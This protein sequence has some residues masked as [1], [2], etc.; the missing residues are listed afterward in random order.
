MPDR[1][2]QLILAYCVCLFAVP[3][4]IAIPPELPLTEI[5]TL[6]RLTKDQADEGRPMRI[7]GV[8]TSYDRD[9]HLA[10]LQDSTGSTYLNPRWEIFDP[11]N[12]HEP[13]SPGLLVE[14][15]G[16]S[17]GGRF[18]PHLAQISPN[19]RIAVRILGT[20]PLPPPMRPPRAQLLDP[21]FHSQWVELDAFVRDVR[22]VDRRLTLNLFSGGHKFTATIAGD[23]SSDSLPLIEDSDVRVR[24]VFGSLFNEN[25]QLTGVRL[26][27]PSLK[28]VVV[29][30]SKLEAAFTQPPRAIAEI[31]QFIPTDIERI[32]VQGVVTYQDPGHGFYIKD[33]TGAVWVQHAEPDI[34]ATGT[35]VDIVAF[36]TLDRQIPTLSDAVIHTKG[37]GPAPSPIPVDPPYALDLAL[38]GQLV[39]LEGIVV[40]RIHLPR[41]QTLVIESANT[42]FH[43]SVATT[44]ALLE[45]P[46]PG[47]AVTV[48]GICQN[49]A[50][51]PAAVNQSPI[52]VIQS[53]AFSILMRDAQDL[54]II[55]PPPWWTVP[56]L[57]YLASTLLLGV[58][59]SLVWVITL[60]KRVRRQSSI[61]AEKLSNE[62]ISEER[63]RIA[64]ELH[65]TLEQHLAGVAIQLDAAAANLPENPQNASDSLTLGAAML[66]HS[67][68]EARR[69]VWDL[70]SQQLEQN[71]LIETLKE[72]AD[73]MSTQDCPVS[74]TIIG[75][76]HPLES[77]LEFHLLRIAQ[78]ALANSIKHSGASSIVLSLEFLPDKT[79]LQIRDNGIGFN[80]ALP[81]KNR[82]GHFGLLGIRE[83]TSK[84]RGQ[85]EINS[86][87]KR[88]T[89]ITISLPRSK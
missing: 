3:K 76:P 4:A 21:K 84:I 7:R 18:A 72:L 30:D 26:F 61:I 87:P 56:R 24:G 78:E 25:R 71:G 6:R 81:N 68:T 82:N 49:I 60:K 47:T 36:A 41:R 80:S 35:I 53:D 1:F 39:K 73:S 28:D 88:G 58:T 55:R 16:I 52:P 45:L 63:I 83:R 85:L 9:I 66:R 44:P 33:D 2:I 77:H 37:N 65:D 89:T 17:N 48:T 5:G 51:T 10:F 19:N 22:V 69:S 46:K 29:I 23:F 79:I 27:V 38:H 12:F 15:T 74:F 54:V 40:D 13:I 86:A 8:L 57:I 42:V 62:R 43:A 31:A 59:V 75:S 32:R 11:P 50:R 67:R 70:R 14:A 20:A 34:F 64:R